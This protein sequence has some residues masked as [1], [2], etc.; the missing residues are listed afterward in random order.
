MLAT[1]TALALLHAFGEPSYTSMSV[2]AKARAK[3]E[4]VVEAP[5]EPPRQKREHSKEAQRALFKGLGRGKNAL[6]QMLSAKW[7]GALA[8]VDEVGRGPLAGPVVAA[9]VILPPN[10]KIRGITDSKALTAEERDELDLEIRAKAI[11]FGVGW[12]EHDEIDRIN[13]LNASLKAMALAVAKLEQRPA[14]LLIDGVFRIPG[15]D[16]P[17]QPVIKGDLRCRCIGAASILAK[18]HRDRVMTALAVDYPGYGFEAHKGYP[19]ESHREAIRKLGPSPVHRR[20]FAGVLPL[21]EREAALGQRGLFSG[22]PEAI[23]SEPKAIPS[24]EP[25]PFRTSERADPDGDKT[26][27]LEK[28]EGGEGVALEYLIARGWTL[29]E[30]N[31]RCKLGELDLIVTRGDTLAFVEVKTREL[32]AA[33]AFQPEDAVT[34]AKCKKIERAARAWLRDNEETAED[35]FPRFDVITVVGIGRGEVVE[36]LEDA[37]EARGG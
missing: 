35:F 28:G 30:R 13:I 25:D 15:V 21:A 23:A 7:G 32:A 10:H 37:F 20:S 36:H 8:G 2:G 12:V 1:R 9:A 34:P 18:V 17:Q 22:P 4:T 29:I 5:A 6:E 31:W 11:A 24:D 3:I 26:A 16:L 14:G 33:G 19:C 27:H